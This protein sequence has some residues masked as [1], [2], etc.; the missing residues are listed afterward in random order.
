MKSDLLSLIEKLDSLES[1]F[2]ATSHTTPSKV[3]V[4][5]D[6]TEFSA[7]KRELQF[8][9][10]EINN[11]T[12]DKFIWDTLTLLN[13]GF[14]GWN[15]EHSYK[16]LRGCLLTIRKN[17][18][19]YYPT[20]IDDFQNTEDKGAQT[21]PQKKPKVFISHSSKDIEY[22]RPLVELLEDIG[23]TQ[24]QLFCSSIPGYSI[25]LDEDIYDY[26]K[27]QFEAHNPHVIFVLS[28]NYYRSVPC[29]NEMGAAW[30]QRN[31]YTTVLLPGFE[32]QQMK[33]AINPRKNVLKLD[34]DPFE[35]KEKL[36]QI[37]NNLS[38]E[39]EL[40][41]IA[42]IRWEQKRDA[43]ISAVSNVSIISTAKV[44]HQVIS[45]TALSLLRSASE[46]DDGTILKTADLSGMHIS[47]TSRSFINSQ[48]QRE[49]AIWESA[50]DELLN[51]G[52][53]KSH[54]TKGLRFSITKNGYDYIE[55][56]EQ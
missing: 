5:Y 42:D 33:G 54:G 21:M 6:R 37:K 30:I 47:T 46:T 16:E 1:L 38:Q 17:I 52:L 12:H 56:L 20:E 23:L 29:M 53:I 40:A 41:P 34:G 48:K 32:F 27:K 28:E 22:V 8:E 51:A 10:E 49:I 13:Q 50:L 3:N 19:K 15:D 14:N 43:F 2:H 25:P 39:F 18:N 24:E 31:N 55:Q 26:L 44:S 36:G 7:W 35:V 11:R 45:E 9:L 4:V